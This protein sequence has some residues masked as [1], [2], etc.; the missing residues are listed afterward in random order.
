MQPQARTAVVALATL[1]CTAT[2]CLSATVKAG[3]TEHSALLDGAVEVC[4]VDDDCK[5]EVRELLEELAKSAR[6]LV[7]ASKGATCAIS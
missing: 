4:K 6:C 5:A 2:G 1:L 3:L 7:Q